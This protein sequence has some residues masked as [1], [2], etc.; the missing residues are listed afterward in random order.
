MLPHVQWQAAEPVAS[1]ID[2]MMLRLRRTFLGQIAENGRCMN[3]MRLIN[4]N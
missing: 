2:L 4:E 3:G 1:H